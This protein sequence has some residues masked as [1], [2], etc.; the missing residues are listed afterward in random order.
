MDKITVR[1]LRRESFNT[2]SLKL[3]LGVSLDGETVAVLLKTKDYNQLVTQAKQGR[4]LPLEKPMEHYI[5]K[6]VKGEL[7]KQETD[8]DGYPIYKE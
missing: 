8:M 4:D 3:P 2:L 7:I 5:I 1:D 6:R